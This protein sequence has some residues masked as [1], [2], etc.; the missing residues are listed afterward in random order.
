MTA[1]MVAV[2]GGQKEVVGM[3][4]ADGDNIEAKMV[5]DAMCGM[6]MIVQWVLGCVVVAVG[7]MVMRAK[8]VCPA[9]TVC[10]WHV[11]G[12]VGMVKELAGWV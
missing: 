9:W 5:S 12:R 6:H 4:L 11:W 2:V 1:L 7:G 3:L 10:V 8:C